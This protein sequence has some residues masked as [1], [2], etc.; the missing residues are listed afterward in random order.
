MNQEV[1]QDELATLV[2][3]DGVDVTLSTGKLINITALKIKDL[4]AFSK[5]IKKVVP[6]AKTLGDVTD[7]D[8]VKM[9]MDDVD[10]L[11]DIVALGTRIPT[12]E[13]GELGADDLISLGGAVIEVNIDF[14][15]VRVLPMIKAVSTRLEVKFAKT[16]GQQSSQSSLEAGSV[17]TK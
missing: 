7:L 10:T 9:A 5:L 12:V 17:S 2:G 15:I 14:F 13:L 11:I 8:M 1:K 3:G 16:N 6:D 4:P